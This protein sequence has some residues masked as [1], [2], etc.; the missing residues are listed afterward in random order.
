MTKMRVRLNT[1]GYEEMRR[2][3]QGHGESYRIGLAAVHLS[4]GL[5]YGIVPWGTCGLDVPLS[6][7][8]KPEHID[9][10][11]ITPD[12]IDTYLQ[13]G[14]YVLRN[15]AG[16]FLARGHVE[17]DSHGSWL[18]VIGK[19][20]EDAVKLHD[21]IRAG[22]TAPE[23]A[24]GR[25]GLIRQ[26]RDRYDELLGSYEDLARDNVRLAEQLRTLSSAAEKPKPKLSAWEFFWRSFFGTNDPQVA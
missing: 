5:A 7:D 17:N 10:Y 13:G 2:Q 1:E 21:L 3:S 9:A 22:E 12:R 26:L 11:E 24:G 20:R 15:Q 23:S 19:R 14:Q 8:I 4:S 6:P 25:R 18:T 16:H